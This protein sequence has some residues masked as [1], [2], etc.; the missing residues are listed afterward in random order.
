[1]F[2]QITPRE[3]KARRD[4]GEPLTLID[5]REDWEVGLA[6]VPDALNIPMNDIPDALA[7]IPK[8]QPVV[9]LCH[10]GGRSSQVAMWLAMQGFNNILN[11]TGGIDRWSTEVD[12]SVPRY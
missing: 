2:K 11:L 3:V 7:R 8:E 4:A 1:M 12:P 9:I 6:S 5:I 10:S